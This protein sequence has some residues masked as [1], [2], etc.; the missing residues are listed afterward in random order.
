MKD[1][2]FTVCNQLTKQG[3][4]PTLTRV[5]GELGG[6]SFSTINPFL[7][8]WTEDRITHG[9]ACAIDLRNEIAAIS[10]KTTLLIWETVND[11]YHKART[12]QE[13]TLATLQVKAAD[14]EVIK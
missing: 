10:Q 9:D 2:V 4:K 3:I 7:R 11:R 5:R 6:G 8:Q 14:A 12:D 1:R 13:E